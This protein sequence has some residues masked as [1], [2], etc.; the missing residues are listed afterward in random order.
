M[1]SG[2]IAAFR[3]G[4]QDGGIRIPP[5]IILRHIGLHLFSLRKVQRVRGKGAL[6]MIERSQDRHAARSEAEIPAAR[7]CK[8]RES[9]DIVHALTSSS[10]ICLTL[11]DGKSTG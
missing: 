1:G 9:R 6:I 4:L 2:L 5:R 3:R 7:S 10:S 8:Q 11:S